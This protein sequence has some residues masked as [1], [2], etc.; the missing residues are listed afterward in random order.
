MTSEVIE[1]HIRLLLFLALK[2]LCKTLIFN[3][4]EYD[5]KYHE[6]SHKARV[7]RFFVAHSFINQF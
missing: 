2:E 7:S 6:R 1:G 5:P 4:D 3:K